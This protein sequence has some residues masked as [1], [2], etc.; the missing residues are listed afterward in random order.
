MKQ[1]K[2]KAA[3]ITAKSTKIISKKKENLRQRPFLA[4]L[5]KSYS[6]YP[7]DNLYENKLKEVLV[8]GVRYLGSRL[9]TDTLSKKNIVPLFS[10][11]TECST[12][13]LFFRL[14]S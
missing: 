10:I 3:E 12:V 13:F 8:L 14:L 6:C 2:S 5:T 11:K 4:T 1:T 9:T 7:G